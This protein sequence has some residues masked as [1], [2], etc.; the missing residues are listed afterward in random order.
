MHVMGKE[1]ITMLSLFSPKF[2]FH[3]CQA[4]SPGKSLTAIERKQEEI[5]FG[6]SCWCLLDI[7]SDTLRIDLKDTALLSLAYEITRRFA[8]GITQASEF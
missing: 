8:P 1:A 2:A 7:C 4:D 5:C 3:G 6:C